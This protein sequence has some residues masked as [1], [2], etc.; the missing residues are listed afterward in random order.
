MHWVFRQAFSPAIVPALIV[1]GAMIALAVV[2]GMLT[3]RD[4]FASTPMAALR[5][6]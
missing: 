3:G 1:A 4:V 6:N 2:I 5:E